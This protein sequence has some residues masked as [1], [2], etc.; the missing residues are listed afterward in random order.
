MSFAY[1]L[2][3]DEKDFTLLAFEYD[4][5]QQFQENGKPAGG[6]MGGRIRFLLDI[7]DE[8]LFASWMFNWTTTKDGSITVN[9]IDQASK[10]KE[11]K[12]KKA[13][14]MAMSESFSVTDTP[15][16]VSAD[17][18]PPVFEK[19]QW[20]TELQHRMDRSYVLFCE[21]SAQSI[22]IDGIAH[23]NKW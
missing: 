2:R 3:I 19:Y 15:A 7:Q 16:L 18:S 5:Q 23:D 17:Y 9:R 12:F 22:D 1:N 6:V 20:T 21:L 13:Y 11:L 10:F 14:M 8:S 4:L